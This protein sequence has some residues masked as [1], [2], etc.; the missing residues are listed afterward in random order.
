MRY[1]SA[2]EHSARQYV[3][4][5]RNALQGKMLAATRSAA[6]AAADMTEAALTNRE[7]LLPAQAPLTLNAVH[8]ALLNDPSAA[9]ILINECTPGLGTRSPVAVFVGKEA[10]YDSAKPLNFML[11]SIALSALWLAEPGSSRILAAIVQQPALTTDFLRQPGRMYPAVPSGHTWQK[12]AKVMQFRTGRSIGPLTWGDSAHLVELGAVPSPR[13]KG[14]APSSRRVGF[15]RL[16]MK[17]FA[18]EGTSTVVLHSQE[19]HHENSQVDLA[20]A[21]LGTSRGQLAAIHQVARTGRTRSQRIEQWDANGRRVLRCR[22]LGNS[23]SDAL[24]RDLAVLI[25]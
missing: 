23:I 19:P 12:V 24:L 3:A 8:I 18:T 22:Q 1:E 16:L 17:S 4:H 14:H 10:A 15:L 13:H 20:A 5:L 2:I 11:V 25:L 6:Q 21:F 9:D 7:R